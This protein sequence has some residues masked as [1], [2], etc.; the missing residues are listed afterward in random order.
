MANAALWPLAASV[1]ASPTVLAGLLLADVVV[2][3]GLTFA[4][5]RL[6]LME[7]LSNQTL[8]RSRP[9]G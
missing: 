6:E 7:P 2:V 1:E 8:V 9:Q 3:L 5:Y 4:W